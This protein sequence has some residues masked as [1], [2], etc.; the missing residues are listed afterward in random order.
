[1]TSASRALSNGCGSTSLP[2]MY[3]TFPGSSSPRRHKRPWTHCKIFHLMLQ[4]SF[5]HSPNRAAY[6]P[7]SD[8]GV[9]DRATTMG[10]RSSPAI[11][12]RSTRTASSSPRSTPTAR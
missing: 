2:P 4:P 6:P 8:T 5:P 1:M 7:P 11:Q 10:P 9:G 12:A 3:M